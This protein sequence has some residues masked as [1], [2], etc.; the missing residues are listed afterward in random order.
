MLSYYHVD[1]FAQRP[2]QGNPAAVFV[3]DRQLDSD[4]MRSLAREF[5]MPG[6]GFVWPAEEDRNSYRIR[7]FTSTR[8]IQ[9]SGH[10]TLACAQVLLGRGGDS[11]EFL[12]PRASVG[13]ERVSNRLWLELPSVELSDSHLDRFRLASALGLSS[14]LVNADL[15]LQR[16]TDSDLIVP[17]SDKADPLELAPDRDALSTLG[18]EEGIR[19]FCCFSTRT[20]DPGSATHSRFFAPHFGLDED[21]A[22]GSVHGPLAVYLWKQGMAQ[23]DGGK[24][25]LTCEQ[26]DAIGRPSRLCL[27]ISFASGVPQRVRVGGAAVVVLNG[28][29]SIE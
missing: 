15:P 7:Y 5:G 3:S 9:L 2:L 16:T 14:S 25:Q 11:I 20:Q 26:G 4:V 21:I 24:L 23:P 29:L 27:E 17:L 19:G 6:N 28:G 1:V 22:T 12:T 10:T 13:V 18:Q 8:E